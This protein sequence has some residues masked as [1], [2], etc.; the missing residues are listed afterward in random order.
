MTDA[1]RVLLRN[2]PTALVPS[3]PLLAFNDVRIGFD[4]GDVLRGI[5]FEVMPGE[6]KVFLGESGSGKTLVMKL[7]AGLVR[8]DSGRIWVM[9]HNIGEMSENELLDFRRH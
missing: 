7:A 1:S 2:T 5:S 6:T 3:E 9:G 4:Q 8:P